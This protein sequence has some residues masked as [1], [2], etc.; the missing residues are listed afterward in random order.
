M[1]R[2]VHDLRLRSLRYIGYACLL[3]FFFSFAYLPTDSP[4]SH[5]SISAAFVVQKD[6]LRPHHP[7]AK[8]GLPRDP[9]PQ[10][11]RA[12]SG[13]RFLKEDRKQ[14]LRLWPVIY[15]GLTRSPPLASV[16]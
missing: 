16:G 15:T 3:T 5:G 11:G 13:S 10:G 2:R 6:I 7:M 4:L 8:S 12:N 9:P 1:L 14:N